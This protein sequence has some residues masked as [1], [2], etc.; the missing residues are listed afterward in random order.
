MTNRFF[1]SK[2]NE[3]QICA[4]CLLGNSFTATLFNFFKSAKL[5]KKRKKKKSPRNSCYFFYLILQ[6]IEEEKL[7]TFQESQL[8]FLKSKIKI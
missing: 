2:Y 3:I 4:L 7:Q 8:T 1:Q 6:L 5:S